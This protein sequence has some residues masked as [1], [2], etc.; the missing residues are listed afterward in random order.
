MRLVVDASIG[1][2]WF[3]SEDLDAEAA[4]VNAAQHELLA[5]ELFWAE[6][7]H[8]LRKRHRRGE[9]T[10]GD[11][12]EA[13]EALTTM[14]LQ[15]VPHRN[16]TVAAGVWATD[17]GISFYDGVYLAV[18]DALGASVVTADRRLH[19]MISGSPHAGLTLWIEDLP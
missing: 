3:L 12:A 15:A 6:V 7:G 18:A 5:P 2:K 8:V 11:V 10:A 17:L 9:L 1:A 13:L 4:R 16:L 14:P 19:D